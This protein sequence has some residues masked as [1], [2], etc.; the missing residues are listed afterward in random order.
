MTTD[1]INTNTDSARNANYIAAKMTRPTLL[2]EIDPTVMGIIGTEDGLVS[3]VIFDIN[4]FKYE[5]GRA[6]GDIVGMI[7]N[8]GDEMSP[9]YC[10]DVRNVDKRRY[11]P[12]EANNL[13]CEVT[14]HGGFLILDIAAEV[15][16]DRAVKLWADKGVKFDNIQ[17]I[18][19]KPFSG[20][21]NNA[22]FYKNILT[23]LPH[24][25]SHI[26]VIEGG[27]LVGEL[28]GEFNIS[29]ESDDL[30]KIAYYDDD[31]DMTKLTDLEHLSEDFEKLH[32]VFRGKI[33]SQEVILSADDL[34]N[35][36]NNEIIL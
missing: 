2:S 8:R 35:V 9:D 34:L 16:I 18:D 25:N 20:I 29:K 13:E 11:P 30:I 24:I 19:I 14:N 36:N 10:I 3:D 28:D 33:E 17:S 21:L 7:I 26:K 32:D 6:N 5:G 31:S 22:E 23:E 4:T 12:Y 1:I 15:T 27:S